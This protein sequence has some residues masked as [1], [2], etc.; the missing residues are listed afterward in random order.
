MGKALSKCCPVGRRRKPATTDEGD[1]PQIVPVDEISE[2]LNKETQGE[3]K[4][5]EKAEEKTEEKPE[6]DSSNKEQEGN[7]PDNEPITVQEQTSTEQE[8]APASAEEDKSPPATEQDAEEVAVR[9]IVTEKVIEEPKSTPLI[10]DTTQSIDPKMLSEGDDV[11]F[12]EHSSS[13][14]RVTTHVVKTVVT[15]TIVSGDGQGEGVNESTVT[16]TE[17]VTENVVVEEDGV[18]KT[19]EE[20]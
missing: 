6:A 15:E 10:I 18:K 7:K 16:T 4:Q 12:S 14:T 1:T 17:T 8:Q 5:E 11:T 19:E 9:T 20:S 3:Q 13:E 2:D